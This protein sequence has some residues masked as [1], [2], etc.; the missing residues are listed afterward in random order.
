M[1]GENCVRSSRLTSIISLFM[2][3]LV[4]GVCGFVRAGGCGRMCEGAC[5]DRRVSMGAYARGYEGCGCGYG[6]V[7][8]DANSL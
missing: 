7:S 4:E 2:E 6:F 1:F 5:L 8:R 3:S